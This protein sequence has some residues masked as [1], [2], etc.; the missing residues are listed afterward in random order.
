MAFNNDV[1]NDLYDM[2][3]EGI[4]SKDSLIDALVSYM[5]VAELNEC[6]KIN[7]LPRSYE[8]LELEEA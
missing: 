6:L 3:E 4:I 1:R 8:E 5:S 2:L 7:E